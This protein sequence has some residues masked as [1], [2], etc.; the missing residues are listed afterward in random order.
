VTSS[1][2]IFIQTPK[3]FTIPPETPCIYARP[4]YHRH[5]AFIAQE[6]NVAIVTPALTP[7]YFFVFHLYKQSSSD[8]RVALEMEHMATFYRHD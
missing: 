2:S 3:I 1:W 6:E 4:H 7:V 8:N 5:M